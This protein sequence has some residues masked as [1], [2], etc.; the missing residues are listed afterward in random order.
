MIRLLTFAVVSSVA[1]FAMAAAPDRESKEPVA[2]PPGLDIVQRLRDDLE[3]GEPA[4][5]QAALN[6]IR[7]L[8]PIALIPDVIEAINDPTP[9]PGRPGWVFVGHQAASVLAEIARDIDGVE[10]GLDSGERDPVN[11]S[12][13]NDLEDG[14][15]MQK[16]G[17]LKQV[18]DHWAKWWDATRK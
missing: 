7:S 18:R 17:R 3:H 6:M 5:K 14:A 12:F 11:Y 1:A 4:Q 2:I 8:K 10:V 9:L 13:R 16:A 15:K